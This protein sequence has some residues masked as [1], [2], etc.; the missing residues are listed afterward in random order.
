M[1]C[2]HQGSYG[3]YNAISN[4]LSV[5]I[6]IGSWLLAMVVLVY[7]YQGVLMSYFSAPKLKPTVDTWEQLVAQHEYKL[8]IETMS[9]LTQLILVTISFF[10]KKTSVTIKS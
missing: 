4:R 3:R 2:I 7:A 8:T 9:S 5:R 10:K 1:L 6:L